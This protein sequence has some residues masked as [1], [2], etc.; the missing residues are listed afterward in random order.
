MDE[1]GLKL[2]PSKD[3]VFYRCVQDSSEAVMITDT[4]GLLL[5]VNPAWTRIYGYSEEEAIGG[6]PRILHSGRQ[7]RSYYESMWRDIR[8]DTIGYW[9]GELVNQAKDGSLIPVLLTI[10]PIR[11]DAGITSGYVGTAI[12]LRNL[13]EMERE[14]RQQDRL[15]S[16]GMITSGLAH[17]IG[18]PL[19]VIRGRAEMLKM[20]LAGSKQEKTIDIIVAQIDRISRLI[21]SLLKVARKEKQLIEVEEQNISTLVREILDLLTETIK[22]R[23]IDLQ[24]RC[25]DDLT[26]YFDYNQLQ[27]VLINLIVNAYQAI[28]AARNQGR[29]EGHC[30]VIE[31][32]SFSNNTIQIRISDTGTGIPPQNIDKLFHP[33]FT[34]K[35]VGEGTGLGLAISHKIISDMNGSIEVESTV[36]KG[37]TFIVT[38]PSNDK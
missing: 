12:D 5:Y 36:N 8:D 34:T 15:A 18:T 35:D 33:F 14:M 3:S 7:S 16:I 29:T 37:T 9:K 10:S 11:N 25:D 30:L 24:V 2:T 20:S 23:D 4:N 22:K 6:S 17:E 19:G 21:K 1:Y 26:A 28:D 27:Q 38:L 32:N 13:R 31:A